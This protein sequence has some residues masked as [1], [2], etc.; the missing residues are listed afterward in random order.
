MK[1]YYKGW[2]GCIVKKWEWLT[3][4]LKW[5]VLDVGYKEP[6]RYKKMVGKSNKSEEEY[7]KFEE[8][9]KEMAEKSEEE[10]DYKKLLEPIYEEWF[11]GIDK[12]SESDLRPNI[13]HIY[14]ALTDY[15]M[16]TEGMRA[17][18]LGIYIALLTGLAALVTLPVLKGDSRYS[19]I[20]TL[21]LIALG[22]V[23]VFILRATIGYKR[24]HDAHAETL[25]QID[26]L[27]HDPT[28]NAIHIFKGGPYVFMN[29]A[30]VFAVFSGLMF[31][32][33]M[34]LF[35]QDLDDWIQNQGNWNFPTDEIG[36]VLLAFLIYLL[37]EI[38][39]RRWH[40]KIYSK[41][42]TVS[43]RPDYESSNS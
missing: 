28:L 35:L 23:S 34:Y 20:A 24:S 16:F 42:R 1:W 38:S 27:P 10:M 25:R 9:Y 36:T 41:K 14:K 17:R 4:K 37:L 21:V 8:E 11:E 39:I 2:I 12:K 30:R 22:F 7:K 31:S 26:D 5:L 33:A 40:S 29:F 18:W 15:I 3:K 32:L 6:E 43:R 19:F 13:A